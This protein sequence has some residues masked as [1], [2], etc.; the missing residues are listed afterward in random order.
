MLI[1]LVDS[2]FRTGKNFLFLEERK[3]VIQEKKIP[4]YIIDDIEVSSD[5]NEEN[6]AEKILMKK[7]IRRNILMKK[8][9]VKKINFFFYIYK[10]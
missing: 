4:K 10:K 5:S 3:Y 2:V 8:I 1:S 9:L 6:S 7:L